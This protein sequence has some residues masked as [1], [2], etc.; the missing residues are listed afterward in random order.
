MP[1]SN[2]DDQLEAMRDRF[3]ERYKKERGFALKESERKRAWYEANAERI[4]AKNLAAY[5]AKKKSRRTA[6]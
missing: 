4:K 2:R 1:Y 5:H 6:A 3:A